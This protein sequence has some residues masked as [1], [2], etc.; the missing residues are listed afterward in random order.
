MNEEIEKIS[1]TNKE[2]GKNENINEKD[3]EINVKEKEL[4]SLEATRR[5]REYYYDP[6]LLRMADSMR[7]AELLQTD[8]VNEDS[9]DSLED[10]MENIEEENSRI[11]FEM[12][13]ENENEKS[14]ENSNQKNDE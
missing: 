12:N 2:K 11:H 1:I 4:E 7:L 6:I 8:E 14:E 5:F 10:V 3:I 13:E 9:Y